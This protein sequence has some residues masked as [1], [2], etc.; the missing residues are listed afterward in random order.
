MNSDLIKGKWNQL[1]GEAKKQWGNLTDDDLLK[2]E[3]NRDKFV[4]VIQERYGKAKADAER[5]VDTWNNQHK[6][7]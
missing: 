7:W 3:G 5:E 6:L 2:I 4:G 1:K